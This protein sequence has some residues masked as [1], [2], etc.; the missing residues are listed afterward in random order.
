MELEPK[1]IVTIFG[2]GIT[3]LVSLMSLSVSLRNSK[4]TLYIN[5]I[6]ASRIKWITVT[7]ENISEFCG[8]THH[9]ALTDLDEREKRMIT[10]KIDRLRYLIKLQLNPNDNFDRK[11][12]AKIDLIPNLTE[13]SRHVELETEIN[14][15]VKLTQ[16]LLKLE[17]EGAKLESMKG[18]IRR[19]EK[20]KLYEKYL[21]ESKQS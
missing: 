5:S 19:A 15:L 2:I 16:D 10:E 20:D 18:I 21:Q 1:D 9:F 7:R 17:W 11:I 14:E 6:T 12:M 4:K 13:S 3:F 8:L